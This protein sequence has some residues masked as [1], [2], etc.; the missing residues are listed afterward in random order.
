MSLYL[1]CDGCQATF[2][3]DKSHLRGFRLEAPLRTEAEALGWTRELT[4]PRKP[5]WA[6][7]GGRDFCPECSPVETA[8]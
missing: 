8:T 4:N 1:E 3:G 7:S 6:Q 5:A 2:D